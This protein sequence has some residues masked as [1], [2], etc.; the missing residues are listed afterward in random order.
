MFPFVKS[1][2]S[3]KSLAALATPRRKPAR[4]RSVTLNR[5]G[6]AA[7]L[8]RHMD[9]MQPPKGRRQR[10]RRQQRPIS[11]LQDRPVRPACAGGSAVAGIA[12]HHQQ[13]RP[14]PPRSRLHLLE[15]GHR[16][17]P[18]SSGQAHMVET[19]GEPT[20]PR[21]DLGQV[22]RIGRRPV[23]PAALGKRILLRLIAADTI[24]SGGDPQTTTRADRAPRYPAQSA[25]GWPGGL[26]PV[27]DHAEADQAG[28]PRA[29]SRP[30]DSGSRRRSWRLRQPA[31]PPLGRVGKGGQTLT[32]SWP[33]RLP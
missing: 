22:R 8:H 31:A 33:R 14:V 30:P 18:A 2:V 32:R 27:S 6:H 10:L 15:T 23:P 26:G 3:S 9:R 19:T 16:P 13:P 20:G 29:P 21:P 5:L 7:G 12:G 28:P 24:A 1:V 11:L 17:G 25:S 4:R